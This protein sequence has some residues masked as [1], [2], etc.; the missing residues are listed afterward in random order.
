MAKISIIGSG[1]SGLSAACFAAQEGHE[2]TVF[3]KNDII[4][5]LYRTGI[6][7]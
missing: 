5:N 2:V 7:L 1:F 4:Q 3:E 6:Y